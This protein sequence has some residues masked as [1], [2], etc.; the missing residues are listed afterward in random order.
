MVK[1][2]HASSCAVPTARHL[3]M[4]L[5]GLVIAACAGAQ[6]QVASQDKDAGAE[7]NAA[8]VPG[9]PKRLPQSDATRDAEGFGQM[10]EAVHAP[11]FTTIREGLNG[12]AFGD[13]DANGY[14]DIVAV[15]TPP[16]ALDDSWED[17][18]GGVK[19]TRDPRDRLHLLL[20]EGEFAFRDHPIELF[21][22]PATAGEPW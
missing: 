10:F 21:G 4:P 22:S 7:Q 8:P 3:L 1:T 15:T 17:Q 14:L 2:D 18:T 5:A 19:R 9:T 12:W 6:T 13:F 11:A 16:F 20:N